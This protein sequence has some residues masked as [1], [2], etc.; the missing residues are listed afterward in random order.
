MDG[1]TLVLHMVLGLGQVFKLSHIFQSRPQITFLSQV[2]TFA[3]MHV[4]GNNM[5]KEDGLC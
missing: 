3:V 4:T 2:Q 5:N 1:Q